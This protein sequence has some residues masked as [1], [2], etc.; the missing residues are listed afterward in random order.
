VT[1][2]DGFPVARRILVIDD[3]EA[4]R[5]GV[6][7]YLEHGGWEVATAGSGR[8]AFRQFDRFAPGIVL[9][10]VHLDD[11]S[12]LDLLEQFKAL[13]E[14]TAV[15][16]ISGAGTIDIAV[17]AMKRGAET[18][19]Q[20]PFEMATLDAVLA[21]VEKTIATQRELALLRRVVASREQRFPGVSTAARA[22]DEL[23]DQAARAPSPVL[24]EGE[25]GTGKGVAARMVHQR[26]PRAKAPLVELNCAGLSR[27]LLESELFGHEKGAFTDASSSKPGLFE[28]AGSGTIFLDEI[29]EMDP[30]IQARLLKALE[31][32]TFRRVGGVRD[33]RADF[34]LISATNRDLNEE[35][36]AGRFRKDLFYRLNVIRIKI[37]PLRE[38]P[39]DLVILA[40]AVLGPLQKEL[41]VTKAELS[42]RALKKMLDYS[43][44]GNV[45]ELRNVLERALIV[46]G[47]GEIKAEHLTLEGDAVGPQGNVAG[48]PTQKWE[49]QPLDVVI[50]DYVKK[51]VEAVDGNMREASRRLEISP[52]TLYARLKKS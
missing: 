22:L 16:M 38:R 52:S 32:K 15:I 48:K 45:R 34:R 41:G 23:I 31:D 28:L 12:G 13:A 46:T 11:V 8:E 24:L 35:V 20:K 51:A 18:F 50:T 7:A 1:S 19:L 29:G 5:S 40:E 9:A 6:A 39:D 42:D 36:A 43:W 27:E 2:S 26:S 44:P 21:H 30:A 14:S 10:D 3:D 33:I 47:G 4:I 49:I 37:P 17:Q 25:S